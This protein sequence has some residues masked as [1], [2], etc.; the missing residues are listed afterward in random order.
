MRLTL[1]LHPHDMTSKAGQYIQPMPASSS[2]TS[3]N[4]PKIIDFNKAIAYNN[5]Q[6]LI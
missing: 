1:P 3:P 6:L 5:G 4:L 2:I